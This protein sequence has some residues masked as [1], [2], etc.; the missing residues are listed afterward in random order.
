MIVEFHHPALKAS[1]FDIAGILTQDCV[2]RCRFCSAVAHHPTR[3]GQL[4]TRAETY[5]PAFPPHAILLGSSWK[6][7]ECSELGA[8]LNRKV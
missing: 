7:S 2:I 4:L 3:N 6:R 5:Y 1:A 8:V